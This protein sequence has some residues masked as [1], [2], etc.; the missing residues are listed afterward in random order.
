ML[1]R[2]GLK[3]TTKGEASLVMGRLFERSKNKLA[4]VKQLMWLV[5]FGPATPETCTAKEAKVFLDE[6]FS[7]KV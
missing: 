4:S 3:C 5:R 7:K 2:F 6:R 1:D